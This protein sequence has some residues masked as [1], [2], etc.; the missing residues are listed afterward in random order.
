MFVP[1]VLEASFTTGDHVEFIPCQF[2]SFVKPN[3][4]SNTELIILLKE[5]IN[6]E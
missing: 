2:Q 3:G 6:N 4:N 1:C 5:K